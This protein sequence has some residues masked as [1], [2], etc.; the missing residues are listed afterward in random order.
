MSIHSQVASNKRRTYIVMAL[1]IVFISTLAYIFGQA[2][3]YGMS[4]AGIALVISGLIALWS[5]YFSDSLVLS[6]SGA[7]QIKL[8]DDPELF[9]IVENLSIAS[10]LPMPKVYLIHDSSPNAFATGRDPK[11]AVIAVTTGL[12]E[13]L[14][15]RELEGVIAHEMAHIQNYDIRLMAIVTVLVGLV[16]LL[17]DW[18]MRSFWWHGDSDSRGG[19]KA[20]GI[21]ALIGIILALLSPLIATLIQLAVSR[22]RE[23]LADA[24]G[25][26]LTRYPEGLASALE[27]ISSDRRVPQF[28]NN[29]TAHM[30]IVNPFRGKDIASSLAGLFDTHPPIGERI[31]ALRSM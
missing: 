12:Q 3:G 19:G 2:S 30:F 13:K 27:K 23:F 26:M 10:G 22:R 7:K 4:F 11:H 18:F 6:I 8:Q 20:E 31:A 25:A 5:Y 16:S 14:D 15:K 1:F 21:M 17:A 9:H 29:A 28:A 24:S